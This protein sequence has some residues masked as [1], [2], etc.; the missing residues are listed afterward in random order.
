M[1]KRG[2]HNVKVCAKIFTLR[3]G[4]AVD[5]VRDMDKLCEK[6]TC[7]EE[8]PQGVMLVWRMRTAKEWGVTDEERV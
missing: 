7:I 1:S 4:I 6:P 5:M 8:Q 2:T 3:T